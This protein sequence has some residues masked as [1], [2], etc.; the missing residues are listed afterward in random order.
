MPSRSVS[1]ALVALQ[2]RNFRLLWLGQ[3]VSVTGSSMQTAAILWQVSLLAPSGY[4]G[5]ALGAVG[6]VRVVPIVAFSLVS[7]VVADALDRR[8]LMLLTQSGMTLMAALLAALAFGGLKTLWPVYA[9]ATVS[10]AF[11]VFD[12]PARQSLIPNLVPR[13]HYPNAISLNSTMMQTASVLGPALAGI[14][15]AALGVGWAY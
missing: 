6:L 3:L 11:G 4:K 14:V 9:L 10:A 7:G 5:L 15:L 2:R 13:E 12:A 1:P 8:K